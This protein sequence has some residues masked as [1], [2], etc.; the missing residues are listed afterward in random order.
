[1]TEQQKIVQNQMP[2]KDPR[3]CPK[4]RMWMKKGKCEI[5]LMERDALIKQREQEGGSNKPPVKIGKL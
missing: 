4:H 1:M 5:C 2:L 3:K